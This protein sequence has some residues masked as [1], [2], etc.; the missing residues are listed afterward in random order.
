[1]D[2]LNGRCLQIHFGERGRQRLSSALGSAFWLC[3]ASPSPR[4]LQHPLA[5]TEYP[6]EQAA[7][8]SLMVVS[9]REGFKGRGSSAALGEEGL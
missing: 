3:C 4:W 2:R 7:R 9:P 5:L 1:M 6:R 8:G